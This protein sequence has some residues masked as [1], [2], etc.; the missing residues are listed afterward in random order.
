MIPKQTLLSDPYPASAQGYT[1]RQA[2]AS[3]LLFLRLRF[4]WVEV[5]LKHR[6]HLTDSTCF[7]NII[8]Q[9]QHTFSVHGADTPHRRMHANA[10]AHLQWFARACHS[11]TRSSNSNT[12]LQK[13][14][15]KQIRPRQRRLH[16]TLQL[17]IQWKQQ[18]WQAEAVQ[19]RVPKGSNRATAAHRIR[20]LLSQTKQLHNN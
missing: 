3:H 15:V 8:V 17:S 10:H 7:A 13:H 2:H 5:H 9:L 12:S 1:G 19:R 18:L 20:W 4:V 16:H 14:N 6:C 11:C